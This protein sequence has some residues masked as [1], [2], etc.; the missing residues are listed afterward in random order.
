MENSSTFDTKMSVAAS[1]S[2]RTEKAHAL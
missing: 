1:I 2:T